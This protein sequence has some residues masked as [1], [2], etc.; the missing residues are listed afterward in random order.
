V[1]D[2]NGKAPKL[3]IQTVADLETIVMEAYEKQ[4]VSP[5][6]MNALM[7]KGMNAVRQKIRKEN[8]NYQSDVDAYRDDKEAYMA[9]D[10]VE[11]AAPV[12]KVKK[13][14]ASVPTAEEI[15]DA[16][17]GGWDIQGPNGRVMKYTPESILKHLRTIVE[18]RGRKNTDRLEQIKVMERL[19]DVA[20][21]EYQKIR[22]LLS[23]ISTRFDLTS[24]T[25]NYMTQE[26]WK[27]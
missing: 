19:F 9:D 11:E 21:T 27:L 6:K 3:Y 7:T 16:D 12:R 14:K 17:A 2:N 24:G 20:A 18:A 15:E 26:Q 5:K 13:S 4:K 25:G 10:V 23:L 8:K 1:T 22:V